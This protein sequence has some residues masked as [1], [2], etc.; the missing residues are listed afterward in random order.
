MITPDLDSIENH[1]KQL[2]FMVETE[3]VVNDLF[4][5]TVFFTKFGCCAR[6]VGYN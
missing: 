4:V 2:R 3:D 6:L 5:G 1:D